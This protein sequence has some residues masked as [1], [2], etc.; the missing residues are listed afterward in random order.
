MSTSQLTSTERAVADTL[1]GWGDELDNDQKFW[2]A[3]WMNL[4]RDTI[5]AMR[6]GDPV[7][8]EDDE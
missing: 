1:C 6:T 3:D 5:T 7:I 2:W 8:Y 4:V